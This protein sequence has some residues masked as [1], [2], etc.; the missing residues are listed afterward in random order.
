[1][2]LTIIVLLSG[3]AFLYLWQSGRLGW[4]FQAAAGDYT[5]TTQGASSPKPQTSSSKAS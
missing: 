3:I 1:M 5:V 4:L 2:A